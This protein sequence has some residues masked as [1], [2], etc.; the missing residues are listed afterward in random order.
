MNLRTKYFVCRPGEE[1]AQQFSVVAANLHGYVINGDCLPLT[2]G[3]GLQRSA[4]TMLTLPSTP[5]L[6]HPTQDHGAR[7]TRLRVSAC[8]P[9]W[10]RGKRLAGARA[11]ILRRPHT[12]GLQ[13]GWN[14]HE[15]VFKYHTVIVRTTTP[16]LPVPSSINPDNLIPFQM[17]NQQPVPPMNSPSSSADGTQTQAHATYGSSRAPRTP[18]TVV[19]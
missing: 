1:E 14:G 13:Q 3:P 6:A 9:T 2:R 17:P 15:I 10:R 16:C 12:K 7:N 11:R 19:N 5:G 8:L 4:S 18:A